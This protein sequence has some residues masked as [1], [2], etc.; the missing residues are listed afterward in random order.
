MGKI[1]F[2]IA[3]ALAVVLL[4]VVITG[5]ANDSDKE[6]QHELIDST[7]KKS[8]DKVAYSRYVAKQQ[9]LTKLLQN[10][11]E[12]AI[13]TGKIVGAGVS[14]TQGDSILIAT[15][16]GKRIVDKKTK[17]DGET[18][19]RLGSLSKGFAGVLAA[20]L[21]HE[22]QFSWDD[23][24][25][26][27]IPEFSLGDEMNTNKIKISHIL[28]HSSGTPY[29]SFTNLVEANIPIAKIATRFDEVTPQ[30]EPGIQY[31]YQN[32]MFALIQEVILKTEGKDVKTS[33]QNRF[34]TPLNMHT[35]SMNH[36]SLLAN[37]N[38]AL[39]HV[40]SGK[41]WRSRKLTNKYYN[42]VVA[43]GINA[44]AL[45]MAKWMRFLLGNRPKVATSEAI[46]K[47]FKPSIGLNYN[48]KYYQRWPEHVS[49]QYASGWRIHTLQKN[50]SAP[51]RKM[52]H[53]GGSV[54][55][56]RNEI[57]IYPQEDLGICVLFNGNTS[58][59]KTVIPEIYNLVA[60]IFN[61][62]SK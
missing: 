35:V 52:W 9:K 42:A 3:A 28:S 62:T 24:V 13:A 31:S 23:K 20:T 55:N 11:F 32:A 18:V 14:I 1:K 17:V 4:T 44:S 8:F 38:V 59:A 19:F 26:K 16:F 15:G 27:Y 48:N 6:K 30:S 58:V 29:H 12:G 10:Y 37:K 22:G 7:K 57:A 40:R 25:T 54:N 47:A 50:D 21:A 2:V 45:D 56:Y 49:S 60:E 33:L 46:S 41:G 43:G 34:F 53:H 61:T 39:P 36:K 5:I 51:L